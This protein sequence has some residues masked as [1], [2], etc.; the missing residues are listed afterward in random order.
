MFA[1]QSLGFALLFVRRSRAGIDVAPLPVETEGEPLRVLFIGR[2]DSYKRLDWL[3]ES[4]VA[5]RSPWRLSVVG[6]GPYRSRFEN[7]AHETF[8]HQLPR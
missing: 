7:L 1:G 3:L 4:L 8:C 6:D 5:M 2:L